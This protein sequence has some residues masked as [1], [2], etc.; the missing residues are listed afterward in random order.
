MPADLADFTGRAELVAVIGSILRTGAPAT[1]AADDISTVVALSG[2]P[3]VGKTAL[4]VHLGHKLRQ[5]FPDGRLYLDMRASRTG[6]SR[7]PC[8][9]IAGS[10]RRGP[11]AQLPQATVHPVGQQLGN[12]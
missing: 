3:G 9:P 11:W 12:M 4:A 10:E 6:G 5:Y 2:P 1:A 8:T 7:R